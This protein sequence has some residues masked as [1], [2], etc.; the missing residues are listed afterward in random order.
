METAAGRAV[1]GRG[2]YYEN[3]LY[4]VTWYIGVPAVLLGAFGLAVLAKRGTRALTRWQDPD[5]AARVWALPFMIAVWVVVTVLWR[6]AVAPDQPW[7]S[8]RLVPVVLPRLILGPILAAT[9][10]EDQAAQLGPTRLTS[11]LV[12]F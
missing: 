2:R 11:A 9:W 5:S 6:P 8:R 1:K 7:A 4:W 12:A 3:S 10:L